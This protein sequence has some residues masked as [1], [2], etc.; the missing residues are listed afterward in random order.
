MKVLDRKKA[1]PAHRNGLSYEPLDRLAAGLHDHE[2]KL[3]AAEEEAVKA[4][5]AEQEIDSLA[6]EL[7]AGTLS[8][9]DFERERAARTHNAAEARSR[10]DGLRAIVKAAKAAAEQEVRRIAE[11]EIDACDAETTRLNGELADA[12]ERVEALQA[13]LR[14]VAERRHSF[15]TFEDNWLA[16]KARYD[17]GAAHTLKRRAEE[18]A[19]PAPRDETPAERA[20]RHEREADAVLAVGGGHYGLLSSRDGR[21]QRL[22][23]SFRQ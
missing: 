15:G 4:E 11:R 23:P 16:L 12:Q 17:D 1:A 2:R 3:A 5:Q 13:A 7:V 22:P 20:R 9:D 8:P 19:R 14:F 18:R 21:P 10:R 6:A